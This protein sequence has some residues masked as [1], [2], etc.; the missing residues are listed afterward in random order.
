M[1]TA[2]G[3]PIPRKRVIEVRPRDTLKRTVSS[4]VMILEQLLGIIS[5]GGVDYIHPI[6][7]YEDVANHN[8][9]D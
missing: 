2:S 9:S 7:F 3:I 6:N 4:C 1:D 8:Q 5:N